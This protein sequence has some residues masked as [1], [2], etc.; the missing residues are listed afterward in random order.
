MG[1]NEH[2]GSAAPIQCFVKGF[3][4]T[5]F[6]RACVMDRARSEND[7]WG[8]NFQ[9]VDP[10]HNL[11]YPIEVEDDGTDALPVEHHPL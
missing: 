9:L 4:L 5:L 7:C 10:G 6:C 11:N 2:G 1:C 8:M 3:V